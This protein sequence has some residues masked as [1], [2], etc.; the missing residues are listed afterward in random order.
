MPTPL[1]SLLFV[2]FGLAAA[3][4]QLPT[5]ATWMQ[6]TVRAG[7]VVVAMPGT[8]ADVMAGVV[9][10][11]G[12]VT[13]TASLAAAASSTAM[14]F[15][16]QWSLAC[17]AVSPG[18]TAANGAIRYLL[19]AA[20]P[21]TCQLVVEWTGTAQNGART[22]A[23]DLYGDGSVDATGAATLPVGFGPGGVVIEVQAGVTASAGSLSGPFGS[24]WSY[25]GQATAALR[26][27]LVPDHATV[28]VEAPGCAPSPLP[29]GAAPDFH[30]G[31][32]FT[33]E[34]P[35]G[36]DLGLAVLGLDPVALPLPWSP[37]CLLS[38]DPVVVQM[39]PPDAARRA[40]WRLAVLPGGGPWALRS[41]WLALRLDP[42]ALTTS[43]AL[44][45]ALP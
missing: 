30:G 29:H 10:S 45:V 34:V 12:G 43:A 7:N 38:V 18:T 36:A 21:I 11:A 14:A 1:P 16:A 19:V 13:G 27:R 39:P 42:L 22:L 2:S 17:A 6:G 9:R 5:Q 8:G 20:Q 35:G 33:G 25:Q 32:T 26:L 28:S 44:R 3:T 31:I 15:E 4:A 24:A 40:A 41:Q 37:G 23:I